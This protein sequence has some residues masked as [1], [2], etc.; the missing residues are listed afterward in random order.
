M[1]NLNLQFADLRRNAADSRLWM[2]SGGTSGHWMPIGSGFTDVR[3]FGATGDGTT[4]D[5]AALQAAID[6]VKGSNSLAQMGTR[7]VLYLPE[8]TYCLTAPLV[9]TTGVWMAGTGGG[10]ILKACSG[11]VGTS[12]IRLQ[13]T[14]TYCQNCAF[15]DLGFETAAASGIAAFQ[16]A[17]NT[18]VV[19]VFFERL[20]FNTAHGFVLNGA[21]VYCQSVLIDGV[22]SRGAL[23]KFVHLKGN[24]NLI[25]RLAK[26]GTS[27]STSDPYIQIET[28]AGFEAN[29][30]VLENILLEGVGHAAKCPMVFNGVGMLVLR[31]YWMECTPNNGFCLQIT[32]SQHVRLEG[33]FRGL[34]TTSKLKVDTSRTVELDFADIDSTS[35]PLFSFFDVD[36]ASRLLIHRTNTRRNEHV[37][38]LDRAQ[39]LEVREAYNRSWATDVAATK[40]GYWPTTTPLFLTAQNLLVNPSFEAGRYGWQVTAPD[41]EEYL[42]SEVGVGLMAHFKW[43]ASATPLWW[44]TVTVPT[45]WVGRTLT[46]SFWAK[47]TG[48]VTTGTNSSA[49]APWLSGAGITGGAYSRVTSGQGWGLCTTTFTPQSAGSINVGFRA[50]Q[51]DATCDVY[52]DEFHLAFGTIGILNPGKWASY[53]LNGKTVTAASAAPTTGTWKVGD[54][55]WHTAPTTT[56]VGWTCTTAGSPGTWTPFTVGTTFP[57]LAPDGTQGAPSYAFASGTQTG[58]SSRSAGHICTSISGNSCYCFLSSSFRMAST[59]ALG[60]SSSDPHT[61][62]NDVNLVRDAAQTLAQR[63]A[64]LAQTTRVYRTWTDASNGEWLEFQNTATASTIT[65]RA[66]GSGTLRGLRVAYGTPTAITYGTSMTPDAALGSKQVITATNATAFTINAPTNPLTGQELTVTVRNTSGGA[67]GAATWNAIFKMAAW[68]NPADTFSRSITFVYN[69]TNWVETGRTPADVPN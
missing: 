62:A 58:F 1:T 24:W 4:D 22:Q 66:N 10:T 68:T 69:G 54:R 35:D 30:N 51:L 15:R 55:V 18:N 17:D 57:L 37:H 38:V 27:G 21:G 9:V 63:N 28:Y 53:E 36:S 42:P 31:D 33:I 7:G 8:G 41:T 65:P 48:G 49:V 60:W 59:I 23:D 45:D 16:A 52:L 14:P 47:V 67:L 19:Q 2:F 39:N 25:R 11:F 13:G 12:L 20:W 26:E 56:L 44:Q 5:T 29:G 46:I 40:A 34:T 32:G 64:T 61:A 43:N 50:W 6:A 3:D